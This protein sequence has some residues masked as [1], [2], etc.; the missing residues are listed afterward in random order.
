MQLHRRRH[1]RH[2]DS[3]TLATCCRRF[4]AEISNLLLATKPQQQVAQFSN[5]LQVTI[6]RKGQFFAGTGA[7]KWQHRHGCCLAVVR[8]QQFS[9][10]RSLCSCN[11]DITQAFVSC[12]RFWRS[13]ILAK[14]CNDLYVWMT[15]CIFVCVLLCFLWFSFFSFSLFLFGPRACLQ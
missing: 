7:D 6:R 1:V 5:K 3:S 11:N 13:P 8:K 10:L 12:D 2:K 15:L 4:V 9:L 14:W